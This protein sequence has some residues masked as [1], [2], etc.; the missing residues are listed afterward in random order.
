MD[1]S[2]QVIAMCLITNL[3]LIFFLYPADIIASL[4]TGHWSAVLLGFVIHIGMVSV[5]IKGLSKC[6]PKN[7]IDLFQSA[8]NV[9]AFLMLLPLAV[10]F[11]M[12]LIITV[13][14]YAEI[15]TMVFLAQTPLWTIM[16][17]FLALS[18][19]VSL[20]GIESLFRTSML[21]ALL[22][23]PFLIIVVILSFQNVDWHYMLPFVDR[24]T[25]TFSY[26]FHRP[27]LQSLFAFVGGF[28][29]L[30]FIP[31]YV[32]YQSRKIIMASLLLLPFFL[33]SVYV[34]L[35]TFGE[36][37]ASKFPFPFIMAVD[38]VDISWLMFDR[39][40]IFF[41][42]SLLCFVVLFLSLVMWMTLQLL[43]R[44]MHF[45]NAPIASVLL[46]AT[47]FIVCLLVPSWSNVEQMIWWNTYLR[48]YAAFVIPLVTFALGVSRRRKEVIRP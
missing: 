17:L 35:L 22:F 30:G 12:M 46:A 36:N 16:L 25:A 44:S 32:P 18:T 42:I 48:L 3:G 15:V 26:V 31:P 23:F 2:I 4:S 37:T 29:F 7:V 11:V 38:T 20:W 43:K 5:Y 40:T 47:V 39:I 9:F 6:A 33:I 45:F 13:R 14:A 24:K 8:G 21:I 27:F 34:P 28:L 10:Y 19:L 41:M 1:R